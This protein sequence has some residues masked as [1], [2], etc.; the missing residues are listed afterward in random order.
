MKAA[1]IR[2]T[3]SDFKLIRG[4]KVA[5]LVFEVA[6]EHADAALQTLGGLPQPATEA[7]CGIARLTLGDIS[8][9]DPPKERKRWAELAP[10]QQAAMRC[11]EPGFHRFVG[12]KLGIDAG[13]D[14]AIEFVRETC[15]VRSR[16]EIKT[17]TPA[18]SE[19]KKLDDAYFTWSRGFE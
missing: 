6:I 3:F 9:I 12:E 15:G 18:G 5:Q 1:A 16:A 19:W 11:G 13:K 2:A 8:S 10:S 4:R 17:D 7:W 14:D